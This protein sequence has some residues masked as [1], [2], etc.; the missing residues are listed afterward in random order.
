MMGMSDTTFE[1]I[2]EVLSPIS[3]R[4]IDV[5]FYGFKVSRFQDELIKVHPKRSRFIQ[6]DLQVKSHTFELYRT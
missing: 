5:Y 6:M 4:N 2:K 3:P 1:S